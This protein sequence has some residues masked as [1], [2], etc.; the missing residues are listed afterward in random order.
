MRRAF[1][2]PVLV[3][4][5]LVVLAAFAGRGG[6]ATDPASQLALKYAPVV[7]L[8]AQQEPCG[9][10]E[11]YRPDNVNLV[12]GNDEVALRGP[13]AGANLVKVAPTAHD[14]SA[15]LFG[16]HLDFPG[17][18]L[19]PGCGYEQWAQ[20]LE[21]GSA[22]AMYAHVVGDP[23]H[24]GQ[25][26]LQYWFFYVFNDYNDKHEG[27]WEMIQLDFATADPAQALTMTPEEIGYSQHE[28]AERAHW[29]DAKLEIVDGTHPVVYPA[30]GS[31]ANYYEPALYLGRSAAQGVGCD[32]TAGPSRQLLPT[33]IV[34]PTDK[35]AYLAAFPWLGYDGRWGEEQPGF[36]NGPTGPNTKSQWTAPITWADTSW[37]DAAYAIP[38]G[39]SAGASVTDFFCGSVAAGSNLL[40]AAVD[41]PWP[42]ILTLLGFGLFLCWLASRTRWDLGAP[43]R[44]RRRRPWGSLI[45]SGWHM[46]RAHPRLFLGIGLVFVPL[47]VVITGIQYVVF[48]FAGLNALVDSVGGSNAVVALLAFALGAVFTVLGLAIVQAVTA[49]AMVELD[50]DRAI[51]AWAAY[52]LALRHLRPLAGGLLRAA[53]IVA[54]LDLTVIGIPIAVWLTVRWSL[55]AQVVALEDE[56]GRRALQRSARIVHRHWLRVASITFLVTGTGLLLG[57]LVGTL[58]LLLTSTSIHV[59]NLAA[60]VIYAVTMPLVTIT[61]TYLYFDLF[62]EEALAPAEPPRARVLL[63]EI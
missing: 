15:G 58:M 50:E 26:A 17:S 51:G 30:A 6:A 42:V 13:W 31:H 10:G 14:L 57:P 60:G 2:T 37:R 25:L 1:R 3:A 5:G 16:Y 43:L 63:A 24:P 18:P 28:G 22:P 7:R 39:S 45:T 36:Y 56:P 46:Y 23:A 47:G 44:L 4:L 9:H 20:R 49:Y 29:G 61:T 11:P 27:D 41:N 34:I 40:T 48:K 32:D 52:K 12:L 55:L 62:V 38:A 54:L 19:S 35:A 33:V 21:A 8:V 53:L 59:V